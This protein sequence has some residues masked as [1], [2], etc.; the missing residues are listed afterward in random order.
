MVFSI[1]GQFPF[2]AKW[3]DVLAASK[4]A[5]LKNSGSSAIVIISSSSKAY[6]AGKVSHV[7]IVDVSEI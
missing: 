2:H 3:N 5:Y 7:E 1:S 4:A 6:T